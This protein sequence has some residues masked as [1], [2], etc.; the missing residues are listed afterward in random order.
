MPVEEFNFNALRRFTTSSQD[1]NLKRIAEVH[2]KRYRGSSS[3]MTGVLSH[4]HYLLSQWREI[5]FRMLSRNF[6]GGEKQKSF[7]KI[8]KSPTAIFLRW[9]DGTYAIDGDKEFDSANVLSSLGTSM[10]KLLTSDAM[11]F[12]RYRKS[13]SDQIS[14]EDYNSAQDFHYSTMGDILIRSQLDAYDSRL[15]GTGMFDLK[16]RSVVS[17]R[18]DVTNY[19]LGVGYQ[20]KSAQG[21]WESYEREYF[22]MIRSAFLK[23]SLQV[24]IGRMDGVFVAYHNVERIFGFQYIPLPEIDKTIHGTSNTMIGN[25]EFRMSLG[26]FNRI[27]DKATKKFPKTV[28][29]RLQDLCCMLT[30]QSLRLHFET[31]EVKTPFMYVFAEPMTEVRVQEIQ[32][33]NAAKVEEFEQSILGLEG[34]A[35]SKEHE[36]E[37]E[38][39]WADIEASVQEAV[40]KDELSLLDG[41]MDQES[42]FEVADNL[43]SD[44]SHKH[45]YNNGSLYRDDTIED[46]DDENVTASSSVGDGQTDTVDGED[47]DGTTRS[48]DQKDVEEASDE[49]IEVDDD[50]A[51]ENT[52]FETDEDEMRRNNKE[53][54]EL[55]EI[56][57]GDEHGALSSIVGLDSAGHGQTVALDEEP[58]PNDGSSSSGTEVN[59]LGDQEVPAEAAGARDEPREVLAMTLT[60]RNKVNGKYVTRPTRLGQTDDWTIEYSLAEEQDAKRAWSLYM[61]CKQRRREKLESLGSVEDGDEGDFIRMLRDMSRQGTIW[62]KGMDKKD[63]ARPR[64]VLEPPVLQR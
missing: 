1:E 45:D 40:A 7:T 33:R 56:H 54:R 61:A 64:V 22:D 3:S 5:D 16:T 50:G 39:K 32:S 2:G 30:P 52:D 57:R 29:N 44:P 35:P 47:E 23:Y 25:Q 19:K 6:T 4:F 21:K 37:K 43:N 60:V 26:F 38:V 55:S 8:N 15:P 20:I 59:H 11:D 48:D 27:L 18:M 24:R 36:Q 41:N 51:E 34:G 63:E 42:S 13:N 46:Q 53:K 62:R 28:S 9:R 58:L 31:R 14:P 17:I 10:E 49:K 12:E